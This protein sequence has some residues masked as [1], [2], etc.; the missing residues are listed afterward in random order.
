[1]AFQREEGAIGRDRVFLELRSVS[2][3]SACAVHLC[4]E[5]TVLLSLSLTGG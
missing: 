1:M 3:P 2:G 4:S 5:M